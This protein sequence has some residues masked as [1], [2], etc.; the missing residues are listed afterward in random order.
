[1]AEVCVAVLGGSE[2][3]GVE[4]DFPEF[5][6]VVDDYDVGVEVDNSDD[7]GG[8]EVGKVDAGVVE[9]LVQG[10]ADGGGD[11][12]VDGGG[13]EGVEVEAKVRE[14]GNDGPEEVVAVVGCREEVEDAVFRAGRV[15]E[16]GEDCGDGA[17]EVRGGVV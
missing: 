9:G 6:N 4:V 14:G 2:D 17:T 10:A 16:N 8:E 7:G 5:A 1:M 13:I 15:L 12:V 11:K 3:V